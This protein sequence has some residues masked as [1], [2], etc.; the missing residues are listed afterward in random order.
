ML[1]TTPAP[2]RLKPPRPARQ[3]YPR[4]RRPKPLQRSGISM[5]GGLAV[6][7]SPAAPDATEDATT[8][9][10]QTPSASAAPMLL[11]GPFALSRQVRPLPFKQKPF[12]TPVRRC[13]RTLARRLARRPPRVLS[14]I[15]DKAPVAPRE[16]PPD[17]R[18]L[19]LDRGLRRQHRPGEHS[20]R[21][22][23][24]RPKGA[25]PGLSCARQARAG[26]VAHDRSEER[27]GRLHDRCRSFTPRSPEGFHSPRFQA[28]AV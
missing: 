20:S 18:G 6:A 7:R 24:T 3:P 1:N 14:P 25:Q 28:E 13:Q 10:R 12:L 21:R 27:P 22:P 5:A 15:T 11:A 8:P 4:R 9:L 17:G 26:P 16:G 19:D 2:A 23:C